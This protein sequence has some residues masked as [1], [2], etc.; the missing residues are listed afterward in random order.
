MPTKTMSDT[1]LAKAVAEARLGQSEGSLPSG[2]VLV[3]EGRVIGENRTF[4]GEEELLTSL[5]VEPDVRQDPDCIAIISGF[6][7]ERPELWYEDIGV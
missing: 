1:F 4:M 2:S 5:G 6:V 3:H 7:S